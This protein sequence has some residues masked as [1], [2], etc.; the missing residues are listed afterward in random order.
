MRG[1]PRL[2]NGAI[3]PHHKGT[4]TEHLANISQMTGAR[5]PTDQKKT[6][7][8]GPEIPT[9]SAQ[10]GGESVLKRHPMPNIEIQ[11]AQ[12]SSRTKH[13]NCAERELE[14]YPTDFPTCRKRIL[15]PTQEGT[16]AEHLAQMSQ[17]D[18][19]GT[20]IEG[21]D[22]KGGQTQKRNFDTCKTKISRV[23]RPAPK[24]TQGNPRGKYE[25]SIQQQSP[26]RVAQ[27]PLW[28]NK[29]PTECPTERPKSPNRIP[30]TSIQHQRR[31]RGEHLS[32][33][34]QRHAQWLPRR[35]NVGQRDA[36]RCTPRTQQG[37]QRGARRNPQGPKRGC[38][39]ALR[40]NKKNTL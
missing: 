13:C 30:Q 27:G 17:R 4:P 24:A 7:R 6:Q 3:E 10:K 40:R 28:L 23:G 22:Q 19:Q 12:R 18:A 1:I 29:E 26:R 8:D 20:R 36:P 34:C 11:E 5:I 38:G 25:L 35:Q 32:N 15:R 31:T 39:Q 14:G 21:D 9:P 37:R 2:T 33:I 16:R